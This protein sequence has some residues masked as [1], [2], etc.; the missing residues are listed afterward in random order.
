MREEERRSFS[1]A[2]NEKLKFFI[3]APEFLDSQK[4][5][6]LSRTPK[7][8]TTQKALFRAR[9]LNRPH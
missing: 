1:R 7:I 3:F 9:P 6:F 2:R 8:S 4:S 5:G